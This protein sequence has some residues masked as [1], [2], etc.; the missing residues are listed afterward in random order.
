[1][2]GA[3]APEIIVIKRVSTN[4]CR[5][6]CQVNDKDVS[7]VVDTGAE[8]TILSQ[9]LAEGMGIPI[10]KKVTMRAAGENLTFPAW[11]TK[12]I[13]L[14]IGDTLMDRPIYI[15]PIVDTMLLGFDV[16]K[17][18]GALIDINKREVR[19]TKTNSDSTQPKIQKVNKKK[20]RFQYPV[21]LTED[22]IFQKHS[23]TVTP[24]AI[25]E[26]LDSPCLYF[27]PSQDLPIMIARAVYENH[28]SIPVSFMNCGEDGIKLE[29]DTCIGVIHAADNVQK[30]NKADRKKVARI[31]PPEIEV[32]TQKTLKKEMQGLLEEGSKE[33]SK[34]E[35][36][37]LESLLTEFEDVFSK[38]E[39]DLG[40]F[41][42]V[43][44]SI[45]TGDAEPIKLPLRR[46][47]IHYVEEEKVLLQKMLQSGVIQPSTSSWGAATV[48]VR[49]KGGGLRWCIDYRKL[50]QVTKKDVYPLPVMQECIGALKDNVWFS[51]LDANSAYHQIP[52]DKDSQEK[53]AFR[54]KYGLFEFTRLP[55]GLCNSP[56]TY[57]RAM[58]LVLKGLDWR[59]ALAFLDDV[60][61]IGKT[62]KEHFANL[63]EVLQRFREFGMKLNIKKCAFFQKIMEF[64]GRK[65]GPNGV[66]LTDHSITTISEWKAPTSLKEIEQ[67]LG[68]A[69]YHRNFVKGFAEIEE[70][71]RKLLRTKDYAWEEEQQQAFEKLQKAL[72]SPEVLA[73]P[74][75]EGRY[76]LDCDASDNAIGAQLSQV[77]KGIERAIA[78][79]SFNL[80]PDQRNYCTT[81][82]ELLSVVRFAEHY[83]HY[84]LGKE[85]TCRTDHY[86]L[87][88]LQNFKQLDGQLAR[89]TQR[90]SDYH[91]KIEHRPGRFHTNA[92]ALSR[93]PEEM[94][95]C[96]LYKEGVPLKMLPCG[97]CKYC[98]KLENNWG[99]FS[100]NI[101]D[102]GQLS[103]PAK[104]RTTQLEESISTGMDI[105]LVQPDIHIRA[106]Q[107]ET[108]ELEEAAD[109]AKT[110]QE[111]RELKLLS[112]WLHHHQ[113]PSQ[114]ELNLANPIQ[115]FYY[116]NR[117][118]FFVSDEKIYWQDEEADKLV[119]PHKMQKDLIKACHDIPSAGHQGVDR[120]KE[121]MKQKYFWHRMGRDIKQYVAYCQACNTHKAAHRK[122]K[123]P[124][125][126]SQAGFPLERIHMDFMG[127]FP[128]SSRGNKYILVMVDN[129]TKWCEVIP[130]ES[131]TAEVTAKTAVNEFFC[132]MG[133]PDQ[134][135]SDQGSNFEAELFRN[136]CKLLKIHKKRTTAYRPSANGQAERMNR[137]L[138]NAI[139]CFV[140]KQQNDWD[141]YLPQIASALRATVNRNTGFTPNRLMLGREVAT[142]AELMYPGHPQKKVIVEE[143]LKNLDDKMSEA[144]E[145]AR[146]TLKTRLKRA[147]RY[148]NL[149]QKVEDLQVGDVV[150]LLDKSSRKGRSKKLDPIWIGPGVIVH[151]LTPFLFRIRMKNRIERVVNHDCLKKAN[152]REIPV[153]IENLRIQLGN[154]E[155]ELYC[156]CKKKDNGSPMVQCDECLL[157]FH[158]SC[159][160][161]TRDQAHK[162]PF[163][164]CS[165]CK[166]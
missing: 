117:E 150:Y 88:W 125:I 83:R 98:T 45:D 107:V 18:M 147:E 63:R 154:T 80:R 104:V 136:M 163:Y 165:E 95:Q 48:L 62:V 26:T 12:P 73:I 128:T 156:F 151:R 112:N 148:Y 27:E 100:R 59:I 140:N 3:E 152:L 19:S 16:L 102:I 38:S 124:Q 41:N 110:Q 96:T 143:F 15:A 92:D 53:T 9:N 161:M 34:E 101:D 89:W 134:I 138:L 113:T 64:L 43:S 118:R 66:T 74:S 35:S 10:L 94:D 68:L 84:L 60:C 30:V 5:V 81:R 65:I 44:H 50:N 14:R 145:T 11:R 159:L 40:K 61:V 105:L 79:G 67:F 166:V 54:T 71:L 164:I 131:Q 115:K 111:D 162:L 52:M 4:S 76:I 70:P 29:K 49:K 120:T 99:E 127:P 87:I 78:F 69:N 126:Q 21:Y 114:G 132:R 129:F 17:D 82:K 123:H 139:R 122:N 37:Q 2:T 28:G 121:Y 153:W 72:M 108:D 23:E 133:Y 86:S 8:V 157:W 158:C 6:T 22:M 142:P 75:E 146:K 137:T 130:L 141:L 93:R 46:T 47:P 32:P 149:N 97:G 36:K 103:D 1:M 144:H 160:G 39:L 58:A 119:I 116:M 13:K 31:Q 91:M 90:L 25:Q 135:V 109:I 42:A 57:C 7:A 51:K 20:E 55:F 106:L 85:F 56:S 155:P 24:I 77:Q 33:L